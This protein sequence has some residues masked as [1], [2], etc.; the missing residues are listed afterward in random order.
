MFRKGL[1]IASAALLTASLH[2]EC[3]R[4]SCHKPQH[5]RKACCAPTPICQKVINQAGGTYFITESGKYVLT[6]DATGT[7]G[8][9]VDSVCLDR[10]FHTITRYFLLLIL[11]NVQLNR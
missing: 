2:A 11:Q 4:D 10:S 8:V 3:D 6:E 1:L 7:L 9:A 5:N